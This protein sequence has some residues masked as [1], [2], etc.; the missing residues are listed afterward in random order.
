MGGG[1]ESRIFALFMETNVSRFSTVESKF[2]LDKK[3]MV[4]QRIL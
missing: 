1:N 3:Q 2:Y 4:D